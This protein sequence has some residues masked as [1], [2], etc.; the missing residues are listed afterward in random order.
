MKKG[1]IVDSTIIESSTSKRNVDKSRDPES[2]WTK[3]AGSYKHGYKS[4]IGVDQDSGLVTSNITTPAN[5]HDVLVGND[6]LHGDEE[7]VYGDSG[8]LGLQQRRKALCAK[9]YRI[10]AR[11]SQ[12]SKLP[13]NEQES[14]RWIQTGKARIRAKVEH[15]FGTIKR[16]FG[17]R[18]TVY[19]GLE[20]NAAKM[21]M[22]FALSNLWKVSRC[23][24][25][26]LCLL[27][28]GVLFPKA[29]FASKG[30]RFFY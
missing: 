6:L 11:P 25:C 2:A 7:H 15:C 10:L 26:P 27:I 1:T 18:R 28:Y 22:L 24:N 23:L 4:H 12:I 20:K 30:F 3:K 29:L 21:N 19:R 8:Y 13:V 5:V 17:W 14:A 16:L 9:K